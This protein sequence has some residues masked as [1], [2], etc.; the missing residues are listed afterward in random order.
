M[1]RIS[2]PSGLIT[3]ACG[4]RRRA[5]NT[6]IADFSPKDAGD[7]VR[8]RHDAAMA[9]DDHHGLSPSEDRRAFR[10]SHRTSQST[11]A[12]AMPAS[13]A[14][15]VIR[16]EPHR[17]QRGARSGASARQSRQKL[18]IAFTQRIEGE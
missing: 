12:I 3:C 7:V 17:A 8:R 10:W 18:A 2:R 9:A 4:H 6:A 5:S 11:W 1:A 16:D 15:L 14:W 13:S